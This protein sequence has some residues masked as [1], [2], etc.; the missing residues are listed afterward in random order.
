[1]VKIE[2]PIVHR[3]KYL[4]FCGLFFFL[5][6]V[7]KRKLKQ[8]LS[9][10]SARLEFKVDVLKTLDE[11]GLDPGDVSKFCDLFKTKKIAKKCD[12]EE[13]QVFDT[14]DVLGKEWLEWVRRGRRDNST[15]AFKE[16]FG[17][18]YEQ[19]EE[20]QKQGL[21]KFVF[22]LEV[23]STRTL[24]LVGHMEDMKQDVLDLGEKI[25][26]FIEEMAEEAEDGAL[27]IPD[28]DDDSSGGVCNGKQ[29]SD[30]DP[31]ITEVMMV[32]ENNKKKSMSSTKKKGWLSYSI[33]SVLIVLFFVIF[34]LHKTE[35]EETKLAVLFKH[36][37]I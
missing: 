17:K 4:F 26:K 35:I 27:E 21:S 2:L 9:I 32:K 7:S 20:L 28:D 16:A 31:D 30:D 11:G 14:F 24:D 1:M 5:L 8:E 37:I 25:D 19:L 33:T 6:P 18:K 36:H 15:I 29:G 23:V 3:G 12:V 22:L 34:T 13:Q 10:S